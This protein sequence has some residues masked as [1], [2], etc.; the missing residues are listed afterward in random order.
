[1]R[2]ALLTH[3]VDFQDGQ[4]RVNYEIAKAALD[5]GHVVTVFA[6]YCSAEIAEH[7]RGSF[8]QA[9]KRPIPTQLLRNL[10]YAGKSAS[11]LRQHRGEFD[12]VQANGFVTWEAA[13][14]VAVHFVHS[15]WLRN[16]FFPFHWS[17][18]SPYA[19]YQRLITMINGYYEK[20]AFRSAEELI[21]VS[22]FT[23]GEVIE[24]G[25]PKE[26]IVVV[27]N[28]VDIGEFQ[29]GLGARSEFDLPENVPLALFVGDIKTTRKNLETVLAGMQSIPDLH[30]V[31]AGSVDGSPY[32]AIARELKVSDR[33]HF[34]GKTSKIALLMR[35]TD[36]FVFPSRYEAHPL[37]LLEALASGL[38]VVVS[39]NFGAADYIKAGGIVFD[40]PNDVGALT[41]AMSALV[42]SPEKRKA[43][44][45]A[46]REQALEMQW[47]QMAAKY[48]QIYDDLLKRRGR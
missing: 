4:G 9:R 34:I 5:Q 1:M 12:I 37:V 33:V 22:R 21:A 23:A 48:L 15:A 3:K 14:I 25:I 17:S 41:S 16:P 32:P 18:F 30:L 36:F 10:Y 31:V 8:V 40:D 20:K 46:A 28:G 38:P 24:L 42:R 29:P 43:M 19:Y 13:D 47:S 7:P 27:H 35:S 44:G 6:E 39:G 11:W 2:L 26:K 45:V